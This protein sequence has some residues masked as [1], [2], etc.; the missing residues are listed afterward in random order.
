M[1][2]KKIQDTY[3]NVAARNPFP[4]LRPFTIREN[5]LFFGREGHSEKVLE[6]L[7]GNRFV[8]VTGASGSGKSSLIYCGLIPILYG[9]FIVNAGS[10]WR[11]VTTRPGSSP[12]DNLAAALANQGSGDHSV[13]GHIGQRLNH[14]I[15][16]RSS[17]GLVDVIRQ[18]NLK[19]GENMLLII[20][21]FEELFR[22]IE[23]RKDTTTLNE[24]EAYIKLL[25]EAVQQSSVPIYVVLTMRSDFIGDCSQFQELTNLI[26]KSNFLIPQMT[27]EDFREAILG[28]LA[29]GG[30]EI[31]SQL[32]QH[33]LNAIE[34]KTDQLPVLQHAM[35]RTWE[36]WARYNDPGTPIKMR[37]YEAAGKMENA[38]SM[39]AN[40]SYD[41]LPEEGQ[42]ICKVL[43][44]SLTIKGSDNK[45]IRH[46]AS[47]KTIAEIS[48][49]S[50][51]SVIEVADKFRAKGRSFLTPGEGNELDED[52]VLDISHES[53][54]RIWDKL[55]TW[56][57]E[58]FSSVQMYLRLSEASALYQIGKTGLWRPPDL[59]L[60]LNWKKTQKPTL[61]WA[62]KYNPAF[63]K[64]MVFLDASEKKF[65]QE[66]QNKVRLQRLAISR[67]RRFALMGI[68]MALM[69]V[70]V[71][72]VVYTQNG[73]LKDMTALAEEQKFIAE[74]TAHENIKL[75]E[76]AESKAGKAE[77]D[78]LYSQLAADSAEAAKKRAVVQSQQSELD[79][80]RALQRADSANRAKIEMQ[81]QKTQAEKSAEIAKTN[82]TEAERQKE[83][84][85]RKKLLSI[86]QTLAVKA[87][88]IDDPEL[89]GLLA[90]QAYNFNKQYGGIDN[91]P[92]IYLGLFSALQAF[93]GENFNVYTGHE[94]SVTSVCFVPGTQIFYSSGGDGKICR[95]DLSSGTKTN[96]VLINNNFS[97]RSLT[98]SR[99]GRWL[100]SATYTSGIQLFNLNNPTAS[101]TLLQGHQGW[102]E[103]MVFASDSK[104]LYSAGNDK[105]IIYWDLISGGHSVFSTHTAR[106]RSL[107]IS[108][109]GRSLVGGTDAGDV[110]IWNIQTKESTLVYS[111][112]G[113]LFNVVA[114][115]NRGSVIA[116]GDKKGN[117][118]L[119]NAATYS[120]IRSFSAHNARVVDIK[121]N[122]GDSQMASASLDSKIKIWNSRDLGGRPVEIKV[123]ENFVM[124]VAFSPNGRSLLSSHQND[125]IFVWPTR[126]EYMADQICPKVKRNLNQ[127]EWEAYV[128]YDVDY[129][130]TCENK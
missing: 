54:M 31:D 38:L 87:V 25:V 114:Y 80:L 71:A 73:K 22:F 99:N 125:R 27:R 109:D 20:D 57:D 10:D 45:G 35:M 79:R 60:A 83:V 17:Y 128:G 117:I 12:V 2:A 120:L 119:F 48:G 49:A 11:I 90:L 76:I 53:L 105:T 43:F 98:I 62:K 75:R 63:E 28:P 44:K 95:W 50:I 126:T 37:D 6:Y 93:Y 124:S 32:L 97:N 58:E 118:Y 127:R 96:Q 110:I 77:I 106:I 41:E 85:T 91:H 111:S 18:M 29:V 16:R 129:Q 113:N 55:K 24:T 14:T 103:S 34:D 82:Q 36:F 107:D 78:A 104:G 67:S 4:G 130:K 47:I 121:F 1:S 8:A 30:A 59:Q 122:N 101:F 100:A 84:E 123:P 70:V 51:G 64:V 115:N 94:G 23:N 3:E 69:A 19:K 26:N 56:V 74:Q 21:Q 89:K 68:S 92:D 15:L 72:T 33:I 46:P 40:E 116:A 52:V 86:A 42:Q 65:L 5:H 9:G 88:D 81:R 39:H 61:A 108:P 66:E 7:A 102:V 112:A 13:S